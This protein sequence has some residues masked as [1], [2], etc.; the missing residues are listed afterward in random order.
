M[1]KHP[2]RQPP[3]SL[4][5]AVAAL[6]AHYGPPRGPVLSDPFH[7]VLWENVAYL[8]DDE[9]RSKAFELLRKTTGLDPE[10]ILAA[11]PETLL[12]VTAH[13]IVAERFAGKL[14]EASRLVREKFDGSLSAAVSLPLAKAKRALRKFPGIGE[15]GAEKIL[16]LCQRQPLLA[17][18]SNALRVLERLGLLPKLS[19]Y[20]ASYSAARELAQTE[21]PADF[22]TLIEAHRL[23]R[24]H[25]QEI[26]RRAKPLCP[27]CPLVERCRYQQQLGTKNP[28]G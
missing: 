13:G 10:R 2:A 25:G 15:P 20:A 27:D 24:Q 11:K 19:N 26:C 18:E 7:L 6:R 4:P 8:A 1:S 14:R 12:A 5:E 3:P 21:L 9:K 28:A 22:P 17:P 23:L 16:L